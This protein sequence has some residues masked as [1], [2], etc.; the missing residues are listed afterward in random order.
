MQAGVGG[1]GFEHAE[2]IPLLPAGRQRL[3]GDHPQNDFSAAVVVLHRGV[4]G[5]SAV[6]RLFYKLAEGE[7]LVRA[8]NPLRPGKAQLDGHGGVGKPQTG[9][10][11]FGLLT[12][13]TKLLSFKNTGVV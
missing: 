8:G 2:V 7:H 11:I 4:E 6:L 10:Q 9:K 3:L 1:G 12:E 13:H 5:R